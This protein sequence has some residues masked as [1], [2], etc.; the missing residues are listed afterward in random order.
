MLVG[1]EQ[2]LAF[3][4]ALVEQARHGSAGSVVVRGEPG[5]G[6]SALLDELVSA[7][8]EATVLRTRGLEVEAPL[9]FAALHRLLRPVM[10]L[11][12]EL[13]A[14]QARA[15]RVAFGEE[16]GPAVEPFLVGVAT[17]TMLTAAAEENLVL[18]VVD[19]AHWLDPATAGALLFCASRIGADRVVMVFATRDD[20]ATTFPAHGLPELALNGLSP[21]ASRALLHRHLEDAPAEDVTE[22][23]IA[24]SGGNPLALLELPSE[25]TAAQ[26]GGSSPLPAQLHLTGRV[27]QVFLDR[28]RRLPADVQAFLLLAAADDTG[29]VAVLKGAAATL[30]LDEHA[31]ETAVASGLLVEDGSALAVRHPLV[32]SAIYQA[33][34]GQDRRRAHRALAETLAGIGDPDRETWHR[35]AAAD[36]PDDELVAALELVGSRAQRRG[37][38][39]AALAAYERA[40]DLTT[41]RDPACP[42]DVRSRLSSAWACGQ[43][44]R[45]QT[46]L[47]AARESADDPAP[48]GRHRAAPRPHRGQHRLRDRGPPDLRRGRTSPPTPFD[49]VR[50]LDNAVAAALIRTYGAD[51]GTPLPMADDSGDA[52]SLA[53]RPRRCA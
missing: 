48:A 31:L 27:E 14:P 32:R 8:G 23:L 5:V 39:A 51:S 38:H 49:P 46:L 6:K 17:L 13:P 45:S 43:A 52:T 19:D 15:L 28:S 2:E 34:T 37:G 10:R 53:T 4:A 35:A 12:E 16:D 33:A 21:D 26:L 20:A 29:D 11:R 22:R 24:E 18:C 36:G 40:A 9:P 3:L 50:A 42:S 30:G 1:R 7:T 25:L 41:D 44:A 47:A